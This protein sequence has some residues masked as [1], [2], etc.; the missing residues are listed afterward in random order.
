MF[1]HVLTLSLL[2]APPSLATRLSLGVIPEGEA[3]QSAPSAPFL[4]ESAA[5]FGGVLLGHGLAL[6]L[7]FAATSIFPGCHGDF[8]GVPAE[9]FI[10]AGAAELV[11][12]PLLAAALAY[13]AR[14]GDQGSFLRAWL[15]ATIG[16]LLGALLL[17]PG[18]AVGNSSATGALFIGALV[19]D[20]VL[21]SL[22]ASI[23]LHHADAPPPPR[24]L[25]LPPL[26]PQNQPPPRAELILPVRVAF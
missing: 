12:L 25:D 19:G 16:H 21:V 15:G 6:G 23:G 10:A 9:A 3:T 8:C 7:G 13:A 14:H 4:G 20:A 24:G 22:G 1:P 17:I 26:P 5:A 18:F 11:A 2:L